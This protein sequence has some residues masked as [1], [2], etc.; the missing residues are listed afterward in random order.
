MAI[1]GKIAPLQPMTKNGEDVVLQFCT[2]SVPN[3]RGTKKSMAS[4]SGKNRSDG[5]CQG[6]Q[7]KEWLHKTIS[8]QDS[9]AE[10]CAIHGL[11]KKLHSGSFYPYYQSA[12]L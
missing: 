7:K 6:L 4:F 8:A 12:V 2:L 1:K 11:Y 5:N 9:I 3:F 10:K